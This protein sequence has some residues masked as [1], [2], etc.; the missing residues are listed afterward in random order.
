MSF[1]LDKVSSSQCIY[2]INMTVQLK[3][4]INFHTK[5]TFFYDMI[6]IYWLISIV[7]IKKISSSDDSTDCARGPAVDSVIYST[8]L[9]ATLN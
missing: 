5:E 9:E 2:F 1:F 7:E 6:Q 4:N 8:A 3:M